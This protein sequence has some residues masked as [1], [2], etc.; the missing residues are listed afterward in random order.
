MTSRSSGRA[1]PPRIL[2]ILS[3]FDD[4]GEGR[5]TARIINALGRGVRHTIVSADAARL[6]AAQAIAR[7]SNF[8]LQPPFPALAGAPLPG[9][10][11]TIARAM[12]G[13]DLVCTSNWGAIDAAMAHTLFKDLHGLPPLIHHEDGSGDQRAGRWRTW[14][15]RI[16]LGKAAGLVVPSET[17]EETALVDWQQPLGRVKRIAE[18]IDTKAYAMGAKKDALRILKR[19]GEHWVGT[20]GEG[21]GG[22]GLP[23]LV[24]ALAGLPEDWHL[25]VLGEAQG[26]GAIEEEVTALALD[27]RVHFAGAV[28]DPA[29]VLGLFDIFA[30]AG[31]TTRAPAPVLEA[32]AAGL[33]VV[34]PDS[35]DIA[36]MVARE[37]APF[38]VPA[39]RP[40]AL[41]ASLCA[42]AADRGLR[43]SAGAANRARARSE[44][45]A[46][47]SLAAYQRLYASAMGVDL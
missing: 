37:N 40:D 25:V 21:G 22:N 33:P 26:R 23:R 35:G 36:H 10:L 45:D 34:A 32:M 39:G 38:L 2:H 31:A 4:T 12:K 28:A 8:V 43:E 3:H 1:G 6:G 13:H 19:P 47:R 30:L 18:G 17:L 29:R 7:G 16:A 14:Y 20:P 11:Q 46:E 24:R 44:F 5:R 42:L 15:R 41:G 9:R 27:H